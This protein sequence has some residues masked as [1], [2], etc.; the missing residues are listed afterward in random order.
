MSSDSTPGETLRIAVAG[1]AGCM[2][3]AVAEAVAAADD[4]S[5]SRLIES[6][7]HAELGQTPS[8]GLMLQSLNGQS[9]EG[10]DILIE[11]TRAGSLAE[12]AEAAA[13]AGCAL[14]S[15][16]TGLDAAEEAAI[17]NAANRI[18]VV[19]ARNMSL[20]V[21]LLGKLVERAA[22]VLGAEFDIEICEL[23]HRG[24]RD[25]PSGTARLLGEAAA[26][27][28]SG[29][30]SELEDAPRYGGDQPRRAD[31]IG[32]ASLRGGTAAGDHS[33]FFLGD[34]ERLE[35]T[36]RAESRALFVH[37]ALTAARWVSG[38]PPGLYSMRDVLGL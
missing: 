27:G 12:L 10:A 30:I 2:G 18:P 37:G 38:K 16:T 20:G 8:T 4:L 6:A 19:R 9:L 28:R 13:S 32:F 7:G 21:T 15:G 35:L 25:A 23:H 34:G 3:R 5:L 26:A 17:A 11:F 22:A 33:V 29:E 14:V 24:K 31:G 1:A 36:H